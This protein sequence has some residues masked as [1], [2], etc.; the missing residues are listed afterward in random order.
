MA[1]TFKELYKA[2][3]ARY[4]GSPSLYLRVFHFLYRRV[5]TMTTAPL[6]IAYKAMFRLWANR[7]GLEVPVNQLIRGGIYRS[8]L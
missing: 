1:G 6:K 5:C 4:G 3:M 7:K 2:D 8:S